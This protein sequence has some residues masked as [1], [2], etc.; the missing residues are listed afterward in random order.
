MFSEGTS[1]GKYDKGF[2]RYIFYAVH[3]YFFMF[4]T[5]F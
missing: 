5:S 2:N 4:Y 1:K 3:I